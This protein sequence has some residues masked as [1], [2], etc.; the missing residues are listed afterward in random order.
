MR[1]KCLMYSTNQW[2]S[3]TWVKI[4]LVNGENLCV[5]WTWNNNIR[6]HNWKYIKDLEEEKKFKGIIDDQERRVEFIHH[7]ICA[8]HVNC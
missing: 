2:N 8:S 1:L 6:I 3:I 4:I 5:T 7:N